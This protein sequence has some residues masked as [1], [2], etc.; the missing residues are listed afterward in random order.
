MKLVILFF[1][2]VKFLIYEYNLRLYFKCSEKEEC[3]YCDL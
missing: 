1:Y 3:K 2:F